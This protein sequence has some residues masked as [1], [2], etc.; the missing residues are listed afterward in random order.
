[1]YCRYLRHCM[2]LRRLGSVQRWC[3]PWTPKIH[4]TMDPTWRNIRT[5]SA[6][7]LWWKSI[8]IHQNPPTSYTCND[9]SSQ[10][11]EKLW[12]LLNTHKNSLSQLHTFRNW[13]K[14]LTL[15]HLAEECRNMNDK[16]KWLT[17]SL[18]LAV[19]GNS[20]T[21]HSSKVCSVQSKH[22]QTLWMQ[23]ERPPTFAWLIKYLAHFP[24]NTANFF[25]AF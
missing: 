22:V 10:R 21:V 9:P 4:I 23:F 1:M 18:V 3:W 24:S 8:K 12:K 15:C 14:I 17:C 13:N 19:S 6:S 7:F 20:R 25:E 16:Y 11:I 5:S 2:V